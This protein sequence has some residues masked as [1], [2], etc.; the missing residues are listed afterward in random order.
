[1]TRFVAVLFFVATLTAQ[2][3]SERIF[4]GITT[5]QTSG[6]VRNT[7]QASHMIAVFCTAAGAD[8]T[9]NVQL[10]IEGTL[11]G[12]TWIPISSDITALTYSAELQPAAAY[13]IARANGTYHSVRI[14]ALQ[15]PGAGCPLTV[16]YTGARQALGA[17]VLQGTRYIA[18]APVGTR[19]KATWGL[20]TGTDCATGTNITSQWI[21][22]Q[23]QT[24]TKCYISAKTPP[25]GASL[26]VDVL[27][28]AVTS[29]FAAGSFSLPAGTSTVVTTTA[30]S[31][32]A[33]LVEGDY[34]SIDIEGVGSGT[35][36][37]D[38]IVVCV[39]Q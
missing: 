32:A 9:T 19:D 12:S 5:T 10:R 26:T 25:T 20:C 17:I 16:Y 35:K 21:A 6:V 22:T 31:S 1:M 24:I 7:G 18:Q 33:A 34:L 2:T 36:G 13:A 30:L 14:R 11:D 28:N 4:S 3:T 37:K 27:K 39:S 38:V 15:V 23:T 8:V 29:I